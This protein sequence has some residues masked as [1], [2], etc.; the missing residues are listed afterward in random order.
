MLHGGRWGGQQV[1]AEDWVAEST[2]PVVDAGIFGG[3][4]YA[5]W[6]ARDGEQIRFPDGTFSARGTGEQLV[7]ISR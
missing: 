6:A 7:P 5:W 3:Y 4:G 1:V 2:S